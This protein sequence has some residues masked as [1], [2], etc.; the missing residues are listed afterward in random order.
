MVVSARQCR[1]ERHGA[2][3]DDIPYNAVL[4]DTFDLVRQMLDLPRNNV[5]A[6][7]V[8]AKGIDAIKRFDLL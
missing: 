4:M 8:E 7:D 6:G 1:G 3:G 5:L 2:G